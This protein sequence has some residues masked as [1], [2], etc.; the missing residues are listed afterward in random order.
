[1][2]NGLCR[3]L[4]EDWESDRSSDLE[5]EKNASAFFDL[6]QVQWSYRRNNGKNNNASIMLSDKFLHR[7]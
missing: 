7:S 6:R 1:M 5:E 2:L 4:F 3:M